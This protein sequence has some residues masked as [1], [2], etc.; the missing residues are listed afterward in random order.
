MKDILKSE[1]NRK[2]R[3]ETP[4]KTKNS[5]PTLRCLACLA[6]RFNRVS[7]L[8]KGSPKLTEQEQ[9]YQGESK[10]GEKVISF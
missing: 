4:R 1:H 2:V 5:N 3:K 8:L 6:V 9:T 10:G 7:I